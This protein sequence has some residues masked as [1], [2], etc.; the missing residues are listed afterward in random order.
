M[1]RKFFALLA[2]GCASTSDSAEFTPSA[3]DRNQ[4]RS[5]LAQTTPI[6]ESTATLSVHGLTG[7]LIEIG[8]ASTIGKGAVAL[9]DV[10]VVT[11]LNV[12]NPEFPRLFQPRLVTRRDDKAAAECTIDQF[13][14]AGANKEI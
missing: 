9:G 13:A 1:T 4:E 14:G 5:L 8:A 3:A 11:F 6:A 2:F 12:G 10:W 7:E